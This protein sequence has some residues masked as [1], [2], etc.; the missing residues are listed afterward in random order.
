MITFFKKL[1]Q[2][3][4]NDYKLSKYLLYAAGE[5]ILVVIGILIAL[6]IN[7]WNT[8]QNN[9]KEVLNYLINLKEALN[10]DII[11]METNFSF[12]RTRLKGIF[13]ILEHSDLDTRTFTELNWLDVTENDQEN[14]LQNW[15]FPCLVVVSEVSLLTDR[16]SMSSIQRDLFPTLK[17]AI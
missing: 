7:N 8:N 5:I 14:F 6:S 13:Y 3:L 2:S 9:E 4:L 12:N 15:H 1:R 16:S 17:T 10:K 11:S